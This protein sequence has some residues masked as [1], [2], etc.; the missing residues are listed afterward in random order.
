MAFLG[1]S[2]LA[3]VPARGG[4]KG[5]VRKNLCVVGDRSLIG[6]AATTAVALEW[7]D[8]RVISTDD[9]EMAEEGERFGLDAPFPP[10]RRSGERH[11]LGGRRL[12]ARL[13]R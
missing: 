6:H 3:V 10:S 4:S 12:A 11:R 7:I 9:D 1:R 13:A 8:A 2:V 5:I